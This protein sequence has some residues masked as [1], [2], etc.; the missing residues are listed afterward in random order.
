MSNVKLWTILGTIVLMAGAAQA[1]PSSS[2]KAKSLPRTAVVHSPYARAAAAHA[3]AQTRAS[4]IK[5]HNATMVQGQG[6][7]AA[8]RRSTGAPH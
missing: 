3:A 2:G 7:S 6:M 8:R 1:A 5:A 4:P